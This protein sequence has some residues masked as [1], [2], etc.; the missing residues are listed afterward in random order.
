MPQNA[1][2]LSRKVDECKP[3][4]RGVLRCLLR[5]RPRAAAGDPIWQGPT[6]VH[7]SAQ[8]V[9]F[10][11]TKS[12]WTTQRIP[13]KALMMKLHECKPLPRGHS[14]KETLQLVMAEREKHD[15]T[16]KASRR[17]LKLSTDFESPYPPPRK[18]MGV[19]F[20][21]RMYGHSP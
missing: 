19:S 10:F 15:A 18:C 11:V 16:L 21:A 5:R 2:T 13:K 14:A 1:L 17:L 20:S 6:L 3:L 8:P 7:F 4:R 9:P 12:P